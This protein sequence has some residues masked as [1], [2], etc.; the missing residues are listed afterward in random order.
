MKDLTIHHRINRGAGGS[1]LYDGIAFLLS[2]CTDCNSLMESDSAF[3]EAAR[4]KG[5]KLRRHA[6][7]AIDPTEIPVWYQNRNS[8]YLLDQDGHKTEMD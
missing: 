5:Y 6:K 3:A 7:P 4:D 2:V 8:W 1:K